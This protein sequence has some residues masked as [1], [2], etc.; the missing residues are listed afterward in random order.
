MACELHGLL[1]GNVSITGENIKPSYD[2]GDES[3]VRRVITPLCRVIKKVCYL[4]KWTLSLF[5][6]TC[7][8]R[9]YKDLII[10]KS[11]KRRN[12]TASDSNWCNYDDLN[13][14]FWFV[15]LFGSFLQR[16]TLLLARFNL[17]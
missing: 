5:L 14:Y 12:G 13:E 7:V 17:H 3:F 4:P 15:W 11:Q 1:D 6:Y 9:C 16:M 10:Q 2:G 8:L